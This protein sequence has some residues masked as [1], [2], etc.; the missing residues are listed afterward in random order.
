MWASCGEPIPRPPS[1]PS[2][3]G[4]SGQKPQRFAHGSMLPPHSSGQGALLTSVLGRRLS[5]RRM[6]GRTDTESGAPLPESLA[7]PRGDRDHFVEPGAVAIR[8]HRI[9]S[10]AGVPRVGGYVLHD[11]TR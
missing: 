2:G 5:G 8:K 1:G 7:G 3:V 10:D 6:G 11:M 4:V 9:A